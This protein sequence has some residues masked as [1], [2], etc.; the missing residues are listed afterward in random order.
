MKRSLGRGLSSLL[1][2][3]D[4]DKTDINK[5]NEDYKNEKNFKVSIEKIIPNFNQPRKSFDKEKLNELALSIKE[6]GIIQPIIV[7]K[8][9]NNFEIV[10]GERRWRAAQI[11]LL[12]IVPVIV[13]DIS[14]E[15]ILEFSIVENIQRENLNPLEEAI[16]FERLKMDFNYTQD[17]IAKVL[18]KSRSYI[19]NSLRLLTLPEKIKDLILKESLSYGHAR[20]L[21]GIKNSIQIAKIIIKKNLSVRET[22][23][24]VKQKKFFVTR[25]KKKIKDVDTLNIEKNLSQSLK[26]EVEIIHDNNKGKGSV[27]IKYKDLIEFEKICE[28]LIKKC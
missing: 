19:A 27:N 9:Q 7:R 5:I 21:V 23:K 28:I 26:Y 22:E 3:T 24:L 13:V 4:I 25:N 12:D 17:E 6:N 20:A 14:D 15:K 16:S 10:A 2:E 8:K 18:G 11:A 1:N